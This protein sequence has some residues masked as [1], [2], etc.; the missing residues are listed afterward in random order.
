MIDGAIGVEVKRSKICSA[1]LTLYEYF[2]GFAAVA[3]T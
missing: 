1:L 3:V 2:W